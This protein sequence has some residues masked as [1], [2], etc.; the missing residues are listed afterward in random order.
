MASTRE[1]VSF[2]GILRGHGCEANCTVF[3]TKISVPGGDFDYRKYTIGQVSKPLPDGNYQLSVN[4]ALITV[5]N[6]NGSWLSA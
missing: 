4:G 2:Q 5:R 6:L 1:R 3:A